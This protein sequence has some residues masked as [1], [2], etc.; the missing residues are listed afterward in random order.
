[1][2]ATPPRKHHP[3]RVLGVAF[4]AWTVGW[5]ALGSLSDWGAYWIAWV[6]G[7]FLVPEL[8]GLLVNPL[9]TLSENVWGFEHVDHGHPFDF[10]E[11]TWVHWS[12]AII[13]WGLAVW[14]SGH[15]PF[16]IWR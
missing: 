11:W 9:G 1:M 4:A 12:V 15:L 7:G 8:Y 3:A 13:V 16:R 6:V 14:L 2:A 10:A 5:A